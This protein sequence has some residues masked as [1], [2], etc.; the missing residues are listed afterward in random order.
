LDTLG[1]TPEAAAKPLRAAENGGKTKKGTTRRVIKYV[2][3]GS[4]VGIGV[5]TFAFLNQSEPATPRQV[6]FTSLLNHSL[7]AFP[8]CS[9]LASNQ[10]THVFGN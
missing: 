4:A 7:R 6:R 1:K 9:L 10:F 3:L 8:S 5:A 2:L